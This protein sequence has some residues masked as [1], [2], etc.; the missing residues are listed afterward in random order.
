MSYS[1][2]TL[3]VKNSER[4]VTDRDLGHQGSEENKKLPAPGLRT[5]RV[6][7]WSAFFLCFGNFRESKFKN[8]GLTRAWWVGRFECKVKVWDKEKKSSKT[9]VSAQEI[10]EK[11]RTHT[12]TI[13]KYFLC[14]R[15]ADI[16]MVPK[17]LGCITSYWQNLTVTSI[18]YK[19]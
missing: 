14:Y 2:R 13:V 6:I 8:S 15:E 12:R 3:E 10:L 18:P 11:P 1:N 16:Q 7:C 17:D 19:F 9:A 4:N 5:I